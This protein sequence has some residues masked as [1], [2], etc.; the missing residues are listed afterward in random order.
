MACSVSGGSSRR[1]SRWVAPTG[2]LGRGVEDDA[3]AEAV[4]DAM[5]QPGAFGHYRGWSYSRGRDAAKRKQEGAQKVASKPPPD[6]DVQV[7]GATAPERLPDPAG[8]LGAQ[9]LYVEVCNPS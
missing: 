7:R 5:V 8:C 6:P 3:E 4:A 2:L 1:V 9:V